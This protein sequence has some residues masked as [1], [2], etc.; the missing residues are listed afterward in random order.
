MAS[1]GPPWPRPLSTTQ[2]PPAMSTAVTPSSPPA[3]PALPAA[4]PAHVLGYRALK[5][6]QRAL[7]LATDA[8]RLAHAFPD[9]DQ[10]VLAT[11]FRRSAASVPAAIAAS[12]LAL[13][14]ADQQRALQ[15][16]TVALARLETLAALAERLGVLS[17]GDTTAFL[18][19]SGDVTRLLRGLTRS[20]SA[21]TAA[22]HERDSDAQ[23]PVQHVAEPAPAA[24]A[25]STPA[26]LDALTAPPPSMRAT[27]R[28]RSTARPAAPPA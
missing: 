28:R 15:T 4:L 14:R 9:A 8:H 25:P 23:L 5:L 26:K 13:D 6:W 3:T 27:T 12:S 10:P 19:T 20:I 24:V 16:A 21:R 11:D 17:S 2:T 22:Q 7:D 18:F 1:S